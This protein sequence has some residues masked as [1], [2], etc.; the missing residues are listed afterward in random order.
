MNLAELQTCTVT[1]LRRR[2]SACVERA[3]AL[4]APLLLT[5]RGKPIAI[6]I[7]IELYEHMRSQLTTSADSLGI[8]ITPRAASLVGALK[9]ATT[10]EAD[11]R[12][13]LEDKYR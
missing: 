9:G 13:Y 10:T 11:Y 4:G 12:R 2:P 7:P 3:R 1:E 8:E 5:R 6:L